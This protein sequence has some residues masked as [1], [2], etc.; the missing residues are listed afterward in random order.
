MQLRAGIGTSGV[1]FVIDLVGFNELLAQRATQML[2]WPGKQPRRL[3]AG[4]RVVA[5]ALHGQR[6]QFRFGTSAVRCHIDLPE[7]VLLEA[8][9]GRA[10]ARRH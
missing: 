6:L 9:Y 1:D 2:S 3:V 10:A 5:Y 7:P 8:D 4:Q